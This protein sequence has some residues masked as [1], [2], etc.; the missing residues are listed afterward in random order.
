[1]AH[2]YEEDTTDYPVIPPK[3]SEPNERQ[4]RHANQNQAGTQPRDSRL[5]NVGRAMQTTGRMTER[6]G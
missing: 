4:V 1:M 3:A 5:I 6:R 2:A